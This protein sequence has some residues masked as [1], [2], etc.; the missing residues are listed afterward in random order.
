[1]IDPDFFGSSYSLTGE[2]IKQL[3]DKLTCLQCRTLLLES[4]LQ[5][6]VA[7]F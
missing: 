4:I 6:I 3:L 2:G 7:T 1:M 5:R